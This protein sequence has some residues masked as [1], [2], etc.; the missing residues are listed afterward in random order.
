MSP[1]MCGAAH[2]QRCGLPFCYS[3]GNK[4]PAVTSGNSQYDNC[5]VWQGDPKVATIL[6]ENMPML[7]GSPERDLGSPDRHHPSPPTPPP[8]T[9]PSI[10]A[11][12]SL[13]DRL[14]QRTA[15]ELDSKLTHQHS[16][17]MQMYNADDGSHWHRACAQ[18]E[19]YPPIGLNCGDTSCN[20]TI[21]GVSRNPSPIK[22]KS[23]GSSPSKGKAHLSPVRRYMQR[24]SSA[25]E[26][27]EDVPGGEE[28]YDNV[29]NPQAH[30]IEISEYGYSVVGCDSEPQIK[31]PNIEI[32]SLVSPNKYSS[33]LLH[34]MDTTGSDVRSADRS[35][36][37]DLDAKRAHRMSIASVLDGRSTPAYVPPPPATPETDTEAEGDRSPPPHQET[38]TQHRDELKLRTFKP[39]DFRHGAARNACDGPEYVVPV[40]SPPAPRNAV[41]S[42]LGG[43]TGSGA[44]TVA[45][46]GHVRCQCG[47]NAG[48]SVLQQPVGVTAPGSSVRTATL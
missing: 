45:T 17:Y 43:G 38:P 27:T 34:C 20:T 35:L 7:S 42:P 16:T 6:M 40:V 3:C 4:R 48:E 10:D 8:R 36:D 44:R 14:T 39:K 47:N 9:R 22:G 13:D 23:R 2:G 30:I 41:L 21:K 32:T 46:V 15:L 31:S 25:A 12:I 5:D 24:R 37:G 19:G 11:T 18:S 29:T 1:I 26:E 33:S 28:P